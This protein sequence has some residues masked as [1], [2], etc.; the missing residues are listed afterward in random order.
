RARAVLLHRAQL[1]P[2][3]RAR[4]DRLRQLARYRDNADTVPTPDSIGM[5]EGDVLD[6]GAQ[7][8]NAARLPNVLAEDTWDLFRTV[9]R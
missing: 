2:E 6:R 5:A 3:L 8:A 4:T 1:S 7:G 9:L